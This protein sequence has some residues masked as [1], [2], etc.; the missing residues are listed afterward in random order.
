M[1]NV[2]YLLKI[3][4]IKCRWAIKLK[5]LKKTYTSIANKL[6]RQCIVE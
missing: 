6:C 4:Q 2:G 3:T 5:K 1:Y